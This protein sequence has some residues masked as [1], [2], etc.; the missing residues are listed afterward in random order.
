VRL[1]ERLIQPVNDVVSAE[2]WSVE[3]VKTVRLAAL[4][5]SWTW[6]RRDPSIVRGWI[7]TPSHPRAPAR[8]E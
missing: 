6:A 2:H 8:V 4:D 5:L 1:P 7:L 3:H